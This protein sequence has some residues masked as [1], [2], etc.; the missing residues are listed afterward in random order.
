[1]ALQVNLRLILLGITFANCTADTPENAVSVVRSSSALGA[2][3]S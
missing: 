1:M 3:L 2:H